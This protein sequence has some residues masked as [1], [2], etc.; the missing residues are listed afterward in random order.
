MWW[1]AL[2]GIGDAAAHLEDARPYGPVREV[3]VL[4][5]EALPVPAMLLAWDDRIWRVGRQTTLVHHRDGR[6]QTLPMTGAKVWAGP[7]GFPNLHRRGAPDPRVVVSAKGREWVWDLYRGALDPLSCG[8]P[9]APYAFTDDCSDLVSADGTRLTDAKYSRLAVVGGRL[10]VF[11]AGQL[12][13]FD[14]PEAQPRIA[15]PIVHLSHDGPDIAEPHV[16]VGVPTGIRALFAETGVENWHLNR[17]ASWLAPSPAGTLVAVH[18]GEDLLLLDRP[19]GRIV[20]A[21]EHVRDAVF[22]W[23]PEGDLVGVTPT[24]VVRLQTRP[25]AADGVVPLSAPPGRLPEGL[26]QPGRLTLSVADLPKQAKSLRIDGVPLT[27]QRGLDAEWVD[28]LRV[29]VAPIDRTGLE[30]PATLD[31]D[32]GFGGR[33]ESVRVLRPEPDEEGVVE[34]AWRPLTVQLADCSRDCVRELGPRL[35]GSE[36]AIDIEGRRADGTRGR[37]VRRAVHRGTPWSVDPE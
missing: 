32:V 8:G 33:R 26:V 31:V 27:T 34:L 17:L 28:G 4:R 6:V 20:Y 24:H 21:I 5:S 37:W 13:V 29:E 30:R 2:F 1:L 23:T 36:V 3:E 22:A 14:G 35:V 7:P 15:G 9:V 25:Q 10:W 18:S 16:Y 12:R 19:T 11:G